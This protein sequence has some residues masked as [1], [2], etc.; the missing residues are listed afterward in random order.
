MENNLFEIE[1]LKCSY[2]KKNIVLQINNLTI[3]TGKIVFFVG[4]SGIGKS[5]ILETLGLMN[6]TILEGKKFEYYKNKNTEDLLNIWTKGDKNLSK[7]RRDEFSFIFQQ[8]N[9]MSNFSAY[10]NIMSSVLLQGYNNDEAL[11]RTVDILKRI[12]PNPQDNTRPIENRPIYEYSGG[13]QQRLAFARAIA[14]DF[15]VLFADEPTGNLDPNTAKILMEILKS[16]IRLKNNATA[17]IVSHDM[18]LATSFADQIVMI[19]RK[20]ED[21]K[22]Y[23][24]IDSNSI[25]N[26][27]N[28]K[29]EN[30]NNLFSQ[31][32]LIN[33]LEN[34]K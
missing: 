25:F 30:R 20:I 31:E 2:D 22:S 15:S 28:G 4:P 8:T 26:K 18:N 12:M 13:Q 32:E 34:N 14:P 3:P 17:I 21:E 16:E 5:T 10:E 1:D 7:F 33:K 6:N 23:G 9:L 19:T 29:W 11:K 24:L 27:K